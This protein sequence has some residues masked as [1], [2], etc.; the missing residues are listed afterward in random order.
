MGSI[1]N[2]SKVVMTRKNWIIVNRKSVFFNVLFFLLTLQVGAQQVTYR[3]P[4]DFPIALAGNVGE[5]RANHFH[6][7]IDIKAT[8]GVGSPIYA[9]ADGFVSRIGIAPYGYGNFL[10]IQHKDG[11]TSVYAH[12]DDFAPKLRK[13]LE[14]EQL[15]AK[16]FAVDLFLG[17]EKFPIKSGEVVAKLGNS[18]ASGG[19]HLHFELRNSAHEA[20]NVMA[21][22]IYDVPDKQRPNCYKVH[23][24]E[25]DTI[26]GTPVFSFA[27]TIKFDPDANGLLK[28]STSV[29]KIAKNSYFVY[30]VIDYKDVKT[31]TM[32]IYGLIQEV[33]GKVNFE[34]EI[35]KLN[36]ATNRYLN[37]F[38]QYDLNRRSSKHVVRAYV[39]PNNKLKIYK[40]VV[41]RGI[42][43]PPILGQTKKLSTTLSDDA[44]NQTNVKFDII[45][46]TATKVKQIA[47]NEEI[48]MCSA[49][50]FI[51]KGDLKVKIPFGALYDNA[52]LRIEDQNGL[53]VVGN[54]DVALQSNVT[55][56]VKK[57]IPD[58]L[59]KF[60]CLA[61]KNEKGKLFYAG[62]N[63]EN[64]ELETETRNL[65]NY[66]VAY[67]SVAPTIRQAISSG[68]TLK[69]PVI[70]FYIADNLSGI[71]S[72]D[73]YIDDKWVVGEF[74]PKRSSLITSVALS[75][76]PA[77]HIVNVV[78]V[79]N[80]GN[81]NILKTNYK[82]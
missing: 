15:K 68:T 33:D 35:D 80:M 37:S 6:T 76:M 7:G 9:V 81:K 24:Y 1:D 52:I 28:P 79:D 50:S 75:Q 53:Y 59:Q 14:S 29:I 48:V 70:Q 74:D 55:I 57:E 19:P 41:E 46:D 38:V 65:G 54:E 67:D 30:E 26:F 78:V 40:N 4:V 71:K 82:W 64:G 36:F 32:G 20:L 25:C 72:Y 44:G 21:K 12:L 56:K 58:S 66:V 16:K 39:S 69:R 45:L 31:N 3:S 5:V 27:K 43:S 17:P 11:T 34:F 51:S 60:V 42:V 23:V 77:N 47:K 22:K 73:I 49:E 18:G 8:R 10:T 2:E 63:Y 13:Y 61:R 62:G